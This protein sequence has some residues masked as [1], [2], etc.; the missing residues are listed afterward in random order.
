LFYFLGGYPR[1]S[2]LSST[3]CTRDAC[4]LTQLPCAKSKGAQPQMFP[5]DSGMLC[6]R[7]SP[8]EICRA[9]TEASRLHARGAH[10]SSEKGTTDKSFANSR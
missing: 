8:E 2:G 1:V 10:C 6:E 4:V 3:H 5:N 7:E 9:V